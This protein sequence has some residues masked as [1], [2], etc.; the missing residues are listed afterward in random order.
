VPRWQL[1][2]VA[3]CCALVGW[4]LAY[5]LASWLQWPR[6]HYDPLLRTWGWARPPGNPLPI[7]YWGLAL[8]GAGGAAAGALV[9]L[10]GAWARPRPLPTPALQLLGLWAL[11]ALGLAGSYFTWSLWPF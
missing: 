7:D 8:W 6:L 5:A 10:V 3:A 9:A 11:T 4:A 1:R 2:Y